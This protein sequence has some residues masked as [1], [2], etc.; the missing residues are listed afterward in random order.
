MQP[1][2]DRP[3]TPALADPARLAARFGRQ[4][5]LEEARLEP[6]SFEEIEAYVDGTG[7]EASRA[8]FAERMERDRALAASVADLAALRAALE[9]AIPEAAPRRS[10]SVSARLLPL[11]RSANRR[12]QRWVGWAAAA[13]AALTAA[14]LVGPSVSRFGGEPT[15]ATERAP[16][17][18]PAEA[19]FVDGFEAGSSEGW[20]AVTS[21]G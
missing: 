13:A 5:A 21:D 19:V 20:T 10:H 14:V 12:L 11:H 7:D 9:G 15:I 2:P 4:L 18:P 17:N 1:A 8:L 3:T 6:V 16:A